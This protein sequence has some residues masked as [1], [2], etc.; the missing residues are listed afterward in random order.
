MFHAKAQSLRKDA[1]KTSGCPKGLTLRLCVNSAPLRETLSHSQVDHVAGAPDVRGDRAGRGGG[2][3]DGVIVL[4]YV[5][6]RMDQLALNAI[7]NRVHQRESSQAAI[8]LVDPG[9]ERSNLIAQH[10]P[11]LRAFEIGRASCRER[12]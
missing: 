10:Q 8:E 1:K 12:V 7:V 9:T 5:T 2:Q 3:E 4:N 6:I 11:D